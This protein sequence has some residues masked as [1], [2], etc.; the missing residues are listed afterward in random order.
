[1]RRI[2]SSFEQHYEK[3]TRPAYG[4]R[5]D[6]EKYPGS[7]SIGTVLLCQAGPEDSLRDESKT[8]QMKQKRDMFF[9]EEQKKVNAL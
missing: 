1:M 9:Q 6:R 4:F 2:A 5:I 8:V 3:S 7:D